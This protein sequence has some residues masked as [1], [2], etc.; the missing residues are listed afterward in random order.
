MRNFL[1]ALCLLFAIAIQ[2]QNII[3]VTRPV[4]DSIQ[5]TNIESPDSVE[6]Y[7]IEVQNANDHS[8]I[9][10]YW[11]PTG[12]GMFPV[13]GCN[14]L[15]GRVAYVDNLP[16]ASNSV[17]LTE[18]PITFKVSMYAP[19]HAE[20]FLEGVDN[21]K[22][23]FFAGTTIT[24]PKRYQFYLDNVGPYTWKTM[25]SGTHDAYI[26]KSANS[27]LGTLL[28]ATLTVSQAGCQQK[29]GRIIHVN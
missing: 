1:T 16:W 7:W 17:V 24:T 11:S 23:E 9:T 14:L 10:G 21:G 28:V 25:T 18:L 4:M 20:I 12:E 5:I 29:I 19:K 27:P 8:H 3:Q 13:T 26:L 2:A 15:V 22:I 6:N